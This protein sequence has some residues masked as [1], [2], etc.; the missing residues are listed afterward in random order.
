MRGDR[1]SGNAGSRVRLR[2][3]GPVVAA[4]LGLDALGF[5]DLVA[6]GA[7][8][9]PVAVHLLIDTGATDSFIEQPV[10]SLLN[11]PPSGRQT[12]FMADYQRR[13]CPVYSAMVYVPLEGPGGSHMEPFP[14]RLL[15]IPAPSRPDLAQRTFCGILGRD[16]LEHF[17]FGY[18]G[19]SG[20]FELRLPPDRPR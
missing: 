13:V 17:F 10:I 16:F 3:D 5:H 15:G 20:R 14:V 7:E 4:K 1:L 19:P 8:S 2:H 9:T 12:V 11:L 18:D 6:Y